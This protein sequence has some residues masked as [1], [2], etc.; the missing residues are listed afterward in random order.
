MGTN[1]EVEVVPTEELPHDV[2][3]KGEGDATVVL[4]PTGDGRVGI[5]PED[6]AQQAGVGNVAGTGDVGNLLHLAELGAEAAVHADDL[7]VDD[8][9]AGEAV[10]GVAEGLPKLDG[11]AA[12][13]LVVEAVDAVDAGALVVAAEDKEVL[14]ILDLVGEE[15]AHDLE[16]LLA[17]VD[18]VAEEQVIGL[19][20]ESTVLK[21]TE[22]VCVLSMDVTANF[23]G[24]TELEEHGL[25]EQNLPT[26]VAQGRGILDFL[27]RAD[28]RV[29]MMPSIQDS[30]GA[31]ELAFWP[32]V[33]RII[34]I[35]ACMYFCCPKIIKSNQMQCNQDIHGL[36]ICHSSSK[37]RYHVAKRCESMLCCVKRWRVAGDCC[38]SKTTSAWG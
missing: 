32:D 15:E 27:F 6:V 31:P 22:E 25:T 10:E 23:D 13:A 17:T 28:R 29:S 2:A 12:A 36:F 38:P 35:L 20:G 4:A 16:G 21:Q 18:V 3:T 26:L 1:D 11:E 8:G 30:S 33:W 24:S 9:A 14:R 5:G 19:G 37:Y 34:F 7:V